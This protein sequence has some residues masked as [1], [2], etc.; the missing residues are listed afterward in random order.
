[1]RHASAQAL[2]ELPGLGRI[3]E[4]FAPLVIDVLAGVIVGGMVLAV[5]MSGQRLVKVFK[6]G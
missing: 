4:V 3:L 2:A 1:M 5:V 6:H